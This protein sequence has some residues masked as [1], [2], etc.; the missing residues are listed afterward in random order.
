VAFDIITALEQKTGLITVPEV[1]EVFSLSTSTVNKMIATRKIPSMLIAG[2]RRF[3][4]A[5]LIRW[6]IKKNPKIMEGRID[7]SGNKP[8]A[9]NFLRKYTLHVL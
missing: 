4:P 5:Q 9:R 7:G 1:A 3:D 8:M 6:I 2:S